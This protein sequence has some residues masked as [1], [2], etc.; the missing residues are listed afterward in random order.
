MA[1]TILFD[2]DNTL[3]LFDEVQFFKAYIKKVSTIINTDLRFLK[4][5]YSEINR[6]IIEYSNI[7]VK[8][9]NTDLCPLND[10]DMKTVIITH[11]MDD[12]SVVTFILNRR[13][14]K[15]DYDNQGNSSQ[16]TNQNSVKIYINNNL[17]FDGTISNLNVDSES[18]TVTVTAKMSQPSDSRQTVNL[19]LSSINE[20]IHPYHCLVNNL[21]IEN[22]SLDTKAVITNDGGL[23]WDGD[24]WVG[25]TN[26][27]LEFNSHALAQ[28]YI[29]SNNEL[30]N[31]TS[32][33]VYPTNHGQNL[34]YYKGVVVNLGT[35]IEQN[36][37]RSHWVLNTTTLA[38]KLMEGTFTPKQNK[39]YFWFGAFE[40]FLTG[41]EQGTLVYL[42]TSLGSLT[43]DAYKINNASYKTQKT[44]EDTETDLSLYYLGSAPYQEISVT[45]GQKITK[46]KWEDKND[47]LYRA[48]DEGY[49]YLQFAKD[50]ASLEYS[51]L[52][53]INGNVLPVTS[54][55]VQ[56]S[57]DA[58]Y[59]YNLKLLTRLNIT[60]TT[61]PDIYKNSN[62]F[63]ISIKTITIDTSNMKV[64]LNCSNQ[65]SLTEL[66]E[67]DDIYPNENSDEYIFEEENVKN[68]SKFDPQSWSYI[69]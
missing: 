51:K 2:L 5:S 3:I 66:Q 11:T 26:D 55:S 48:K 64:M 25:N 46:N 28:S 7:Q 47:G 49:D 10:I 69:I 50:V 12:D 63:P 67:I 61:T 6:N 33:E 41:I 27:A 65:K 42:G 60:N 23:F 53:N 19:P 9:N 1:K 18:E 31:Y 44:L 4:H 29:D 8:I 40:N 57:L 43:T 20:Q 37:I 39:Q 16:I 32:Q 24:E 52:K 21:S 35:K 15:L 22:P 17:E 68:Y 38:D 30:S 58:Y 14:D 59:Y 45:N 56:I 54:A 13:H 62:G 34:D 36:I